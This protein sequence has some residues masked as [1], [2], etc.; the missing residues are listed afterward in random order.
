M[1]DFLTVVIR[2]PGDKEGRKKITSA[3]SLGEEFYGGR[4]T[5]MSLADEVTMNEQLEELC[6]EDILAEAESKVAEIHMSA[7]D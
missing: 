5:A 2:L 7:F 1:P 6:G 3:L 4:V